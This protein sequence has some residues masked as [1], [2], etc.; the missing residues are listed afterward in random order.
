MPMLWQAL[1]L[2]TELSVQVSLV[3]QPPVPA[4]AK[5]RNRKRT[6][7]STAFMWILGIQSLDVMFLQVLYRQS[8]L[9]KPSF[10][11]FLFFPHFLF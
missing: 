9:S 4:S 5:H 10:F 3:S 11:L 7:L 1:L 6:A 2:R 8:L